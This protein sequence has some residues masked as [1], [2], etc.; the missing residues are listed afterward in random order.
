MPT[1]FRIATRSSISDCSI[2]PSVSSGTATFPA[3]SRWSLTAFEWRS[4]RG[5]G[6]A[7]LW[8]P[9][10]AISSIRVRSGSRGIE[11]APPLMRSSIPPQARGGRW[12]HLL[13]H[14]GCGGAGGKDVAGGSGGGE[15][16]RVGSEEGRGRGNEKKEIEFLSSPLFWHVP[17]PFFPLPSSGLFPRRGR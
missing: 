14:P 8:S 1:S 3:S 15:G 12:G 6:F 13:R 4:S 17:F 5:I 10:V 9:I 7:S 2:F 11:I 16:G